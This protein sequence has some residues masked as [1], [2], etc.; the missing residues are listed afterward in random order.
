M[1]SKKILCPLGRIFTAWTLVVPLAFAMDISEFSDLKTY[2]TK[3]STVGVAQII[4]LGPNNWAEIQQEYDPLLLG[5][6]GN[7]AEIMQGDVNNLSLSNKAV[8]FQSG[9]QNKVSILQTGSDNEASTYQKGVG[10]EISLSQS[11]TRASSILIQEGNGNSISLNQQAG[12]R[13]D[14]TQK[15]NNYRIVVVVTP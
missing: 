10:N 4:Q 13:Y 7:F 11:A 12:G 1:Y 3:N 5:P 9:D 6:Q 14:I 2:F 15:G 8:A